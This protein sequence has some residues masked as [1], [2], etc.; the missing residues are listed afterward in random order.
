M[1]IVR[2]IELNKEPTMN[3]TLPITCPSVHATA[4]DPDKRLWLIATGAAGGAAAL[5]T[6]IPFVSTFSP[7]ERAKAAG[8]PVE[9]DIS[10]IPPGGVKTVEWRGKPVWVVRRT[11]EMLAALQGHDA[12]TPHQYPSMLFTCAFN[13]DGSR[14]ATADKVGRIVIWD[15]AARKAI[16]T[17]DASL[18]G[19]GGCPF[20]PGAS[21]NIVTEDLVFML[22]AMGIE[23]GIDLPA[24]LKV[25]EIVAAAL[26][27]EPLYGF[28]PD[29]GLPL[30]FA[31]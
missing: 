15:V 21:G 31:A 7:S 22:Q 2:H 13:A 10:D 5:A 23:T 18:G 6:A 28:T 4:H 26:P 29:A 3:P 20:A 12:E 17:L 25:R 16:T 1:V 11:P 14:L 24:L 9:V 30:G 27:G 19:I 8:G